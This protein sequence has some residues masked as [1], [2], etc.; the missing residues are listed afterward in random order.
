MSNIY[1]DV[2]VTFFCNYKPKPLNAVTSFILSVTLVVGFVLAVT[3]VVGG[4]L[5]AIL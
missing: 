4:A 5:T 3:L 1:S 2:P